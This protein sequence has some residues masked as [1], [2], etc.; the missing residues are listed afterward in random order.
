MRY[1]VVIADG[2]QFAGFGRSHVGV[3]NG[4]LIQADSF[5]QLKRAASIEANKENKVEDT[6][7]FLRVPGL[8]PI[9]FHRRNK[10]SPDGTIK[11]GRWE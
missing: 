5:S 6:L 11:R 4:K 2:K 9:V 3:I 7:Y 1:S 8:E 10:K